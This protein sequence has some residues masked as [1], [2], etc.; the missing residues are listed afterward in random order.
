MPLDFESAASTIPPPGLSDLQ[1][2]ILENW[3][4]PV[5]RFVVTSRLNATSRVWRVEGLPEFYS[6]K[7]PVRGELLEDHYQ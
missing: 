2:V 3:D 5:K 6:E 4:F 7:H 1:F